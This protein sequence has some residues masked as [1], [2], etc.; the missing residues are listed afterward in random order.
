MSLLDLVLLLRGRVE[1]GVSDNAGVWARGGA[2][3]PELVL[4]T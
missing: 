4:L 3:T 1:V 2:T